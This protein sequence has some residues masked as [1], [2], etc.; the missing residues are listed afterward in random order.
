MTI[1]PDPREAHHAGPSPSTRRDRPGRGH[2]RDRPGADDP[3]QPK[4]AAEP[5]ER[6]GVCLV[7]VNDRLEIRS[8]SESR[9]VLTNRW[10]KPELKVVFV[11]GD[12]ARYAAIRPRI[13]KAA[14]E[15]EDYAN[16]HFAFR[17]TAAKDAMATSPTTTWTS[18][19]SSSRQFF[20]TGTYQSLYGPDA[21]TQTRGTPPA[22]SMWLVFS[23]QASGT[24]RSGG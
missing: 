22:R 13:E 10:D 4:P 19:S 2:R 23:P 5:P 24:T 12:G 14:K 15:W 21:H 1:L 16:I 7:S 17:G 18:P 9:A 6:P 11:D 3:R 8:I 20:R